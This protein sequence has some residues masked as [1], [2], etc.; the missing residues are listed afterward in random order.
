M[1]GKDNDKI[2]KVVDLKG[3]ISRVW[4]AL[5]DYKQFGE[6]FRVDLDQPFVVG[7]KSTGRMTYPGHENV[8]WLAFIDRM[9]EERLFSFRW[10]DSEDP[11]PETNEDNPA[12]TVEFLLEGIA[13]GTRLTITESGF[14]ALP[15]SR[16][17]EL[18]RGNQE[19]WTIQADNLAHYLSA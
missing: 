3:P 7:G 11:Q 19:G 12:L 2:V 4:Q 14:A 9:D 16:R 6:W 17:I 18:M 15:A 10:Y 8:P 13:D 1:T 5:T